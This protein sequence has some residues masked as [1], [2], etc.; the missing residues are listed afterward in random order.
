MS[1]HVSLVCSLFV[2]NS[3][4]LYEYT[5]LVY[6]SIAKHLDC[7]QLLA[8]MNKVATNILVN[9]FADMFSLG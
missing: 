9:I 4:P 2:L 8:M 5:Q 3:S 1:L 7:F 6:F